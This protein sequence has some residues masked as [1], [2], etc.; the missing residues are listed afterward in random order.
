VNS[1]ARALDRRLL[2]AVALCILVGF[3]LIGLSAASGDDLDG[4]PS[5]VDTPQVVSELPGARTATSNTFALS[6]GSR[7]T[8]VFQAPVNFKTDDGKWQPIDQELEIQADGSGLT[9]GANDFDLSVPEKLGDGAVRLDTG[10]AW[11]S[12]ELLGL[13]TAPA[14]VDGTS[15]TY[16]VR[17]EGISFELTSISAGVKETIELHDPSQPR[18]FKFRLETSAGV[19]PTLTSSG[20]IVFQDD[21]GKVIAETPAPFMEDNAHEPALSNDVRY[22]LSPDGPGQWTLTVNADSDWLS[23]PQRVWPVRIDPTTVTVGPSLDCRISK[24]E[25]TSGTTYGSPWCSTGLYNEDRVRYARS[26]GA[27]GVTSVERAL[28]RFDLSSIPKMASVSAASLSVYHSNQYETLP[29]SVRLYALMQDWNGSA[30]WLKRTNE[31]NWTTPGGYVSSEGAE[32]QSSTYGK[33]EQWWTFGGEGMRK[34]ANRWVNGMLANNGLQVRVGNETP[35]SDVCNRGEFSF[36]NAGWGSPGSPQLSITYFPSAPSNSKVTSPTDGTKSAKRFLLTSAWNHSGVS[37]VT[38][39]YK[40]SWFGWMDIPANQVIDANNQTVTWPYPVTSTADRKSRPLYWNARESMF[41]SNVERKFQIRAVL[42]GDPG[43]DG[44]TPPVEAEIHK[45]IGGPKDAIAPIGPG[46][47]DLLTGNFSISK[48]DVSIPAFSSALEFSRTFSSRTSD[49]E[50]NGV[51]GTGWRPSSPVE[52]AGGSSWAKV[53]TQSLTE[54]G[55]TFK[56]AELSDPAGAVIAFEED[57]AGKF[58]TPPELSGF[59]LYRNTSNGNIE[60]SDPDGNKTVFSNNGS[61]SEYLPV[62]VGMTGGPGNKT[63]MIYQFEGS[64][65][66]LEKMIAPAAPGIECPDNESSLKDGCKLLVFTYEPATKWGAPASAGKRLEK[67]TYYAKGLVDDKGSSGPWVVASYTYNA[68]GRLV[69]ARDPRL[70]IAQQETYTYSATGQIATLSPGALKPWTMQYTELA[71]DAGPG[72]LSSVSRATL[73]ESNPNATTTVAYD[74]PLSGGSGRVNM[75]GAAVA[76]WGQQDLPTDA[77]AIFPPDE[78]PADPPSGYTR[79]T[80]YYMDAEGQTSNVSTPAGAGTTEPSITTSETDRF[81]NVVREL[82]AQNRV[83]A[84]AEGSGKSKAKSQELDT[85]FRYSEDGT[86]LQEEEGPLHQVRLESSGVLV[87]A[88]LLRTIQYDKAF[89]YING[90]E[91]PSPGETKP[92]LPTSETVGAKKTDG[93]IVDKRSTEF[94]YDWKLRKTKETITDP[95][96]GAATETKAVTVYDSETGLPTEMR[97]PKN[98]GGGGAGTTKVV[99]YK[100]GSNISN[101]EQ[102]KF[103]GLPCKVEPAAQPGTAGLPALPIKRFVSYNQLS[104]ALEVTETVGSSTRKAV[105]TYDEAG[106]QKTSEITGGGVPVPKVETLYN[107][108]NG[109]ANVQQIICPGSEPGCDTQATT[110]VYDLLG[111]P[112]SYKD[113]DGNEA[114]T[115][116]DFLGRPVTVSDG[117]GTQTMGYDA[118]TGLLVEL[119]DSA[120]GKFTASYDA[121]GQLVSRG[122]PNGLTAETNYDETGAPVALSYTKASSCGASCNW[123]NFAVERSI[124]GQILLEDGTL[125]K[126][127]YAYDRLGRLVTAKETPTGGSCTTRNYKYDPDSNRTEMTTTPGSMG[128]CSSSGG[129]TQNYSYDNAD[130]LLAEGLTYDDFGRITNLP[131]VYAG[132]KTLTTTYFSTDMVA[133]QSQN[134]V[135][136][137]YQLDATLRQRQRLQTGG[138]AGTEIFHYAGP[139]DSPA[140]T[141]RGSTWTRSIGGIGGELAAIQ[142]SGKEVQLQ[143]TNLHGDVSATAALSSS[144][145]ALKATMT[146]DEFGNPTGG[147]A[148]RF[149]WLGGKQRRTELAS[150]VIQM[151][152]RSYVPQTG[153]FLSVDSVKGGSAS[154][155]DYANADPV[156]D[157]DLDGNCPIRKCKKLMRAARKAALR[158]VRGRG[159]AVRAIIDSIFGSK[160]PVTMSDCVPGENVSL[161]SEVWVRA[162]GGKCVPKLNVGAATN[163]AQVAAYAAAGKGWCYAVN[164]LPIGGVTSALAPLTALAYCNSGPEDRPWSYVHSYGSGVPANKSTW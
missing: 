5:V 106:R 36:L 11:V 132:G 66:R 112:T 1:Y 23:D 20:S 83:R 92:H 69:T 145:T 135:T 74:V 63:R 21:E 27:A 18:A 32:V 86:E 101:C 161:K 103:A 85:Q 51:L 150:G 15:A 90:T 14:A 10:E 13:E 48:T 98:S 119:Q 138:V 142:E 75:E 39:Q 2:C 154:A 37:G 131:A 17:N 73:V 116:Y 89:K 4:E 65:R 114:T 141:E 133:S 87:P 56:W 94:V 118:V 143:L 44:H 130:R 149:G 137:T 72:R 160:A 78:V 126:D 30:T 47:V 79:S 147:S 108:T 64:K 129:S 96:S 71:G 19:T 54:E 22:E 105:A 117:K 84:L 50:S 113:A 42:S 16:D 67:I 40:D 93:S 104:Q 128:V 153:R 53:V 38:F 100:P 59:V 46:S 9:N 29:E 26:A 62:S 88:R 43:A 70:P 139:G 61:G 52:L 82:T 124:R 110:V 123:L 122:L 55:E 57:E 140:W 159:G 12:S 164:T 158:A 136:N 134:G 7:K 148:G 49:A 6:D 31:S 80:I 102:S 97:Q 76:T 60:L 121:D 157:F 8:V 162:M 156:N 58:I 35:C 111:R 45:R 77:T 120:A 41:P 95:G 24:N 107:G 146:F 3:L 81:G 33:P 68:Q 109:A 127:E 163:S 99:Y 34:L 125:G 151:G 28:M 115:T 144:A 155:Y 152:A 25:S 91:T